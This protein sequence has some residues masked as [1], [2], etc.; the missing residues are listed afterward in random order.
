MHENQ[1][2]KEKREKEKAERK[3]EKEER[4][5][6]NIERAKLTTKDPICI[7]AFTD[8]RTL[9]MFVTFETC[10]HVSS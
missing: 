7:V 5:K 8:F 2:E 4:E 3:K 1:S 6:G 9:S 10:F